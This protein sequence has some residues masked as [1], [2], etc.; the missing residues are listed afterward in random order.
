MEAASAADADFA[1]WRPSNQHPHLMPA[2]QPPAL[3]SIPQTTRFPVVQGHQGRTLDGPALATGGHGPQGAIAGN[4]AQ[5]VQQVILQQL[6][7]IQNS[8]AKG[9][10]VLLAVIAE[11]FLI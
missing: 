10:Y 11:S 3:A 4:N 8:L 6:D 2:Q 7:I 5:Q 1:G 9:I